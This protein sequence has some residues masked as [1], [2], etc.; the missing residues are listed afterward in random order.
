MPVTAQAE[1][2]ARITAFLAAAVRGWVNHRRLGGM[3]LH[4]PAETGEAAGRREPDVVYLGPATAPHWG[5]R[6]AHGPAD[7]VVEVVRPGAGTGDR[8]EKFR[9]YALSE[10]AEYW[11]IDPERQTA[12]VHAL[13]RTGVYEPVPAGDPPRMR[14][15][16]LPGL[17]IDPAWL[18]SEHPDPSDA[19][20]AWGLT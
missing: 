11:R 19:F 20:A 2:H 3:L 15:V 17:W 14:S 12:E 13:S 4:A 8:Q 9:E 18:W 5:E 10:V 7:L 6:F 16:V 1:R